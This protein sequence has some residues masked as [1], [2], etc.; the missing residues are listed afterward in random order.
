LPFDRFTNLPIRWRK[1]TLKFTKQINYFAKKNTTFQYIPPAGISAWDA[2]IFAALHSKAN[3]FLTCI[4]CA[5]TK[6]RQINIHKWTIIERTVS[7]N[8][9]PYNFTDLSHATWNL[10]QKK[11]TKRFSAYLPSIY[12]AFIVWVCHFGFVVIMQPKLQ[13]TK[14]KQ[15]Q[16][17]SIHK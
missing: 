6:S 14:K 4:L 17:N 7:L 3:N 8:F 10:L 16:Q 9:C 12:C 15:Q 1:I 5:G 11:D 13:K 2:E